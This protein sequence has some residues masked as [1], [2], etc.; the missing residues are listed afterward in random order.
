RARGAAGRGHVPPRPALLRRGDEA[1][2]RARRVA[3]AG[4]P[5][6]AGGGDRGARSRRG[7]PVGRRA[8]T[9]RG[10]RSAARAY[11]AFRRRVRARARGGLTAA[12]RPELAV[13]GPRP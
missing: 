12:P 11:A 9:D 5:A 6:R 10:A 1:A 3:A 13:P 4:R 7:L 8:W 2:R